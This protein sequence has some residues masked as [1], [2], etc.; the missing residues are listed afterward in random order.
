MDTNFTCKVL[1]IDN[2][3]IIILLLSFVNVILLE[4]CPATKA[5]ANAFVKMVLQEI[6][7]N[8]VMLGTS[9]IQ[10]VDAHSVNV[11]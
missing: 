3:L 9:T 6:L 7:V 10:L 2:V 8:T 5:L 4:V 11:V 1:K